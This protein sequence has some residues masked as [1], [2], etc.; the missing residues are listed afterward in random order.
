MDDRQVLHVINELAEEEE[1]LW[2]RAGDEG[3]LT[4][5][6]EARLADLQVR[7]DQAYDLLAQRRARRSAGLDP[8]GARIRPPT[9]V[10][11]YEQ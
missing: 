7:L 9:V 10:E 11:N 1:R 3:G 5:E 6:D 8:D 4:A 2:V